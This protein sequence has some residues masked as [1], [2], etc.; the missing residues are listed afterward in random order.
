MGVYTIQTAVSAQE[1]AQLSLT[2]HTVVCSLERIKFIYA[3][4]LWFNQYIYT[5]FL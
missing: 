4:Q 3:L 1:Q 2:Q 5:P